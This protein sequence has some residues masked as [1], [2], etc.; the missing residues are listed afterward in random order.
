MSLADSVH[1]T[2]GSRPSVLSLLRTTQKQKFTLSPIRD[3]VSAP[4]FTSSSSSVTVISLLSACAAALSPPMFS[5]LLQ[6]PNIQGHTALSWVIV[7]DRREAFSPFV[8]E[9]F[10]D[11]RL[12]G[13]FDLRLAC[14][15]AGRCQSLCH[16]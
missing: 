15:M 2:G 14:M 10:P 1:C 11:F 8:V 7:N 5:H 16:D 9:S 4:G 13:C 6:T 3:L 12:L